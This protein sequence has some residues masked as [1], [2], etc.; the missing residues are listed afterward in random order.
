MG[1]YEV[2]LGDTLGVG[3]AEDVQRLLSYLFQ[4]GVPVDK[5]AGHFHDTY[6]QAI[7]NVCA[8]FKLGIRTFDSSVGGLG[9]CPF[10]PGARG[11]VATEDLVYFFEQAGVR[12]GVDILKLAE[13]GAWISHAL[14]KQND[15]RAGAA[16][17][18]KHKLFPF[19]AAPIKQPDPRIPWSLTNRNEELQVFRSGPNVKVVLNRPKNGNALT[20]SMASQL[21]QVY[22]NAATDRTITR[23]VITANG[24]FFCTGMNLGKDTAVAKSKRASKDQFELLRRLFDAIDGAPQV[25]IAA[26]NGPAFGGGV[27]LAFACDIRIGIASATVTLSE[28]KLGLAP[29]TISKFVARECGPAFTREAMLS[30]RPIPLSEL[31]SLGLVAIV[32]DDR[33]KLEIAL[34]QYLHRLKAAAPRASALCK[35]LVR[36]SQNGVGGTAQA[37]GIHSVFD[38]MMRPDGE[39]AYGL[40]E[41]QAGNKK[42]DWDTF[43]LSKP[44]P[45]L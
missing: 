5:L 14:S 7:G 8:A 1:C 19:P 41:F 22:E 24:K 21:I 6:G 31:W 38:E 16:L 2:S 20:E 37:E 26:I 30:A 36:F 9:G 45:K 35:D 43:A 11:N 15:S 32:V 29:A 33:E 42:V 39:S 40:K 13:T 10:A 18:N 12:T 27:G 44:T 4:H 25:T 23:I 28:V 17:A 3:V 34:D